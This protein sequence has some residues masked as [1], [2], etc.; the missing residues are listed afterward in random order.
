MSDDFKVPPAVPLDRTKKANETLDRLAL[1]HEALLSMLRHI[2][3]RCL[4]GDIAEAQL[5][6]V[7]AI[8]EQF[9]AVMSGM[10]IVV[11]KHEPAA[12]ERAGL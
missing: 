10:R 7:L 5:A 6:A 12:S 9:G 4:T 8:E 2:G 3:D 11:G 1:S